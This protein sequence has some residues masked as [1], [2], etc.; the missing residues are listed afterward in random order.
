MI[1]FD[2]LFLPPFL[3]IWSG[4]RSRVTFRSFRL[5]LHLRLVGLWYCCC[6]LGG[7]S[8][9]SPSVRCSSARGLLGLLRQFSFDP[10]PPLRLLCLALFTALST[11]SPRARTAL[12]L[13]GFGVGFTRAGRGRIR[14]SSRRVRLGLLG[15][16]G[17]GRSSSYSGWWGFSGRLR[18]CDS[19]SVRCRRC[20]GLGLISILLPTRS[21][22]SFGLYLSLDTD[23]RTM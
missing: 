5:G 19:C 1:N 18:G 8:S 12:L 21:P 23:S 6:C 2:W 20:G 7:G 3:P 11:P 14:R 15:L 16:L 10:F 4:C 9:S 17:L 13:V 22:R